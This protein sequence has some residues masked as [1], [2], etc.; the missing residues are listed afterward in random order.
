MSPGLNT[1][2][3]PKHLLGT[4]QYRVMVKELVEVTMGKVNKIGPEMDPNKSE[5]IR[6]EMGVGAGRKKSRKNIKNE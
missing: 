6:D 4:F 2:M 3:S 5:Y 1:D